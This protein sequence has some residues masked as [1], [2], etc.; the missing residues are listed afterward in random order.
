MEGIYRYVWHACIDALQPKPIVG[1]DGEDINIGSYRLLGERGR[2][3][4]SQDRGCT[5]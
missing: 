2:R 3:H 1:I 4:L 5:K